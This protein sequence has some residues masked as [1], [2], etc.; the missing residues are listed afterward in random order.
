MSWYDDGAKGLLYAKAMGFGADQFILAAED[1]VM[2]FIQAREQG[3]RAN[4]G[5]SMNS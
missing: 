1:R 3:V 2:V 5:I 4:D